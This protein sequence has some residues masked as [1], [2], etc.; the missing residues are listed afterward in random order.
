MLKVTKVGPSQ[1]LKDEIT[2]KW[3]LWNEI[4]WSVLDHSVQCMDV[5]EKYPYIFLLDVL[6]LYRSDE[7]KTLDCIIEQWQD[8][9]DFRLCSPFRNIIYIAWFI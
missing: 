3:D 2:K 5:G 8:S 1:S 9:F 4:I 6:H 7:F